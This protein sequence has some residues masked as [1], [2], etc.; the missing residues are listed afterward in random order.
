[1]ICSLFSLA[2]IERD[3]L[4][5]ALTQQSTKRH[6][7]GPVLRQSLKVEL[8]FAMSVRPT[9]KVTCKFFMRLHLIEKFRLNWASLM[10]KT[11][12]L[13]S[14][15]MDHPF[16]LQRSITFSIWLKRFVPLAE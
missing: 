4:G 13:K 6:L 1:M 12:L 8:R 14:L 16:L 11:E 9:P 15:D 5:D 3:R 10:I 2:A 7:L